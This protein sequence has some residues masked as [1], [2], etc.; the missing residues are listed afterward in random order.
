MSDRYDLSVRLV[1]DA[2]F[3]RGDGVA[4]LVDTEVVYDIDTGL[5]EIPGRTINGLLAEEAAV[6][7]DLLHGHRIGAEC[8]AAAGW[9]FGRPGSTLDCQGH[10]HVGSALL[11]PALRAAVRS[12]PLEPV[13][14]LESLTTIR[15]RTAID[16]ARG[17]PA[18]GALR[19]VR[20]VVRDVTFVAPLSF[21]RAPPTDRELTYLVAF[22]LGVKRG[23][24]NRNRGCGGLRLRLHRNGKDITPEMIERFEV[25]LWSDN[26][27]R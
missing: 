1:S 26:D 14:V 12:S 6:L 13:E 3:G 4:G 8:R 17:A 19:A 11:P 21:E 20:V 27:T 9:L 16:E 22:A 23:G 15:R 2:T 25:G 7:V 24:M 18:R 5:P 10:L